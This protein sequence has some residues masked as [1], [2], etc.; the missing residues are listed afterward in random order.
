MRVRQDVCDWLDTLKSV[1]EEWG[2]E[3]N[4]GT[5]TIIY[6]SRS[7]KEFKEMGCGTKN[8]INEGNEHITHKN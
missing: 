2:V 5:C 7:G 6:G 4:R 1:K 8:K 3:T